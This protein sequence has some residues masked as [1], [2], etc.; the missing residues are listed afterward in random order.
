MSPTA[1]Q[2]DVPPDYP[3]PSQLLAW[4]VVSQKLRDAPVYWLA[5]V[6]PD[7]R[8]H[9]V[10][11]DGTWL[12]DALYYGGSPETVRARN[13]G[14]EAPVTMH[15]GDGAEAIIV[16]G[17]VHIERLTGDEALRLAELST[18]KYA[19]Y[20]TM[21]PAMYADGVLVLRPSRVLAWT[22]FGLDATRFRFE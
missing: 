11:R 3:E 21:D 18:A 4:D 15:I 2:M 17:V 8:P 16:E 12:D 10:P 6:R 7:G 9:L 13:V 14:A 1:E 19:Q 20:G 22:S 5:S